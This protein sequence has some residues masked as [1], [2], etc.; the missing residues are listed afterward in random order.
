VSIN[1]SD[2]VQMYLEEK[3]LRP[4]T[5][6]NYVLVAH[7]F[8]KDV[9][10]IDVDKIARKHL[11]AWRDAV[12]LRCKPISWNTYYRHFSVL[13][14]FA[15]RVGVI[16][17]SP[18]EGFKSIRIG[19]RSKKT[20]PVHARQRVLHRLDAEEEKSDEGEVSRFYPQY[21]W[22]ATVM[23]LSMTGM[24]L[25]QLVGIIWDD[26]DFEMMQIRLE[27]E[28][29]KNH[30]EW[31]VPIPEQLKPSLLVLLWHVKSVGLFGYDR[32]VFNVHDHNSKNILRKKMT[33]AAVKSFFR[34]ISASI[35]APISSHRY[36]HTLATVLVNN[37]SNIRI[38][39][40]IL[41]HSSIEVTAGYVEADHATM[42]IALNKASAIMV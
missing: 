22:R 27:S 13:M 24:R 14:G 35:E 12:L 18:C 41:G 9:G 3:Y 39:Q 40:E 23:T 26:V 31:Y 1:L 36:R 29:S 38:A 5:R 6:D 32:Q 42:A 4:A 17:E 30:R 11:I 25:G 8:S 28:T 2:L 34:R 16:Q 37:V 19:K 21:F 15:V 10:H 7:L 33:R 20:I